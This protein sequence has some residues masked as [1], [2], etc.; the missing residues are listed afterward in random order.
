M[1]H[2]EFETPS[3]TPSELPEL[4]SSSELPE[5]L[6]EEARTRALFRQSVPRG[7]PMDLEALFRRAV[8]GGPRRSS[9]RFSRKGLAAAALLLLSGAAVG[10][11]AARQEAREEMLRLESSLSAQFHTLRSEV[12]NELSD[13]LS[14]YSEDLL[15]AQQDGIKKVAIL[16]RNDYRPRLARLQSRLEGLALAMEHPV[17]L[18][19]RGR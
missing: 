19:V 4:P 9:W 13:A 7:E 2:E 1:N 6:P 8:G 18:P 11:L 3:E 5:E 15:D 10:W 16:L 12:V 17:R 14:R